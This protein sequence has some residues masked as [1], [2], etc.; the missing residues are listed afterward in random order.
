MAD[1]IEFNGVISSSLGVYMLE[2]PPITLAAERVQTVQVPGR[3]GDL[4]I[5]DNAYDPISLPV[6]LYCRD[7]TYLNDIAKWLRGRGWLRLGNRPDEQYKA[8]AVLQTQFDRVERGRENRTFE[9]MFDC[10]PHRY[11][12][13]AAPDVVKT[14]SGV[15]ITNPG[16]A[17]SEPR[18]KI[19]GTGD[20]W[21][22]IGTQLMTFEGVTDGVIVDTE[23]MD[24]FDL[25][26]AALL[27]DLATMDD[28]PTLAPGRN[29]IT[30]E[31]AVTKVTIT[32]RWRN[33]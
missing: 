28:F 12:Y 8:R 33:I 4:E 3:D 9:V 6:L 31:G 15:S 19:E 24:V 29:M 20:F 13:P 26:G 16:N 27:N 2:P 14:T 1:W 22:A 17:P 21:I 7:T 10:Q 30:W 11:I 32:P 18:L 23:L 25:T 5:P